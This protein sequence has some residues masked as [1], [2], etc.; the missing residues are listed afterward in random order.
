M[1]QGQQCQRRMTILGSSCIHRV[2]HTRTCGMWLPATGTT[3][4]ADKDSDCHGALPL[5][6]DS[7]CHGL[8]P[9]HPTVVAATCN[10]LSL[11]CPQ[12]DNAVAAHQEMHALQNATGRE[13]AA[14]LY[15]VDAPAHPQRLAALPAAMRWFQRSTL[16]APVQHGGGPSK[17]HIASAASACSRR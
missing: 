17:S 11:R 15:L 10:W 8:W 4:I 13:W 14:F 7:A 5:P 1:A 2:A 9:V 6:I 12:N 3:H 16:V